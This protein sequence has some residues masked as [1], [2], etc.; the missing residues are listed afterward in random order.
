MSFPSGSGIIMPDDFDVV[1]RVFSD[2]A[3]EPW[4]T[5]SIERRELFA[6]S[7]IDAYRQGHTDPIRLADH[8]RAVAQREFG[9]AATPR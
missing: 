5:L 4:F 1:R 2:I 6:L 9:N 3:A 8:C 7:V